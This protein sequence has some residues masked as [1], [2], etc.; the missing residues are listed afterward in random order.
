MGSRRLRGDYIVGGHC[1]PKA[2]QSLE[3][4]CGVCLSTM[5]F[6]TMLR[7]T[8]SEGLGITSLCCHCEADF[9]SRSNLVEGRGIAA[10][11]SGVRNDI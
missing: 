9:V 4:A 5:K 11:L 7:M 3:I 1:E 2:W 6:F 10:H 8:G